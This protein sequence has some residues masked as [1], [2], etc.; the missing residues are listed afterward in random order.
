VAKA[1]HQLDLRPRVTATTIIGWIGAVAIIFIGLRFF[2]FAAGHYMIDFSEASYTRY[3]PNRGY[4]LVHIVGGS[5][6]LVSG[7]FQI[8]SGLRRRVLKAHR[9]LGITYLTGV[10]LGSGGALY[11]A[12]VSPLRTFG[13]A[14]TVLAVAWLVTSGM[15]FLAI[16]NRRIDAHKEWMVRSYVVTYGFVTFRLMDEMGLFMNLGNERFA[17]IAWLCWTIPLLFAEVALQWKRA[18]GR[19]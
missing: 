2:V 3:W 7:P 14:L 18:V 15:A 10:L 11:M 12:Y 16:K 5:L 6:A 4:L 8:W 1:A 19:G 17:T 9:A 13:V